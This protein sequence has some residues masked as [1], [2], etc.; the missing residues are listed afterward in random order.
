[1]KK[2]RLYL[3]ALIAIAFLSACETADLDPQGTSYVAIEAF[4]SPQEVPSGG[5]LNR[6]VKVYAANVTGEDRTLNL[7]TSNVTLDATAYDI[8]ATVTI[9][10]GSSEGSFTITVRDI[11]LDT[12]SD[13]GITVNLE[14][15]AEIAT[16][17]SF[18]LNVSK[19][20]PGVEQKLRMAITF[21]RYPEEVYWRIQ[22]NG[23]TIY[24]AT[25]GNGFWGAYAGAAR[26]ST[27]NLAFCLAPGD[28][29]FQVYDQY[30]DGAGPILITLP[31]GIVVW[32]TNGA[33]GFTPGPISFTVS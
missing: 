21:D 32:S 13:K 10:A 26:N 17:D 1:M 12:A 25:N 16:G 9:P 24:D 22:Q 20:C 29:T 6:E 7:V 14:A 8:P 19:A 28:Y 11:N 30:Q 18:R 33:Y 3:S 23:V 31:G 5:E 27:A 4:E 15:T 2:I